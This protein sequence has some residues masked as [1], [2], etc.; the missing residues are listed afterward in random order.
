[1]RLTLRKR[2]PGDRSCTF[3]GPSAMRARAYVDVAN[4][5]QSGC[6]TGTAMRTGW[7]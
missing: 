4:T 2:L 5:L 1:V 3:W 7:Q 6:E